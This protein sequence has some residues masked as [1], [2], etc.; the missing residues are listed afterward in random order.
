MRIVRIYKCNHIQKEGQEHEG[1]WHVFFIYVDKL[2]QKSN[3]EQEHTLTRAEGL[4][5]ETQGIH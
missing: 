2:L 5:R 4:F 3:R 1:K